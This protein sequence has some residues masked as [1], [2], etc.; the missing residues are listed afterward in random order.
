MLQKMASPRW[1][2][3]LHNADQVSQ[4]CLQVESY[5]TPGPLGKSLQLAKLEL[6]S[7]DA[8][9]APLGGIPAKGCIELAP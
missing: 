4:V 1:S 5:L 3:V 6:S 9:C 2:A 8:D 7:A